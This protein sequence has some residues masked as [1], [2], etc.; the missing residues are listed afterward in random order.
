MPECAIVLKNRP[1]GGTAGHNERQQMKVLA[2]PSSGS[3]A[4]TTWSHNRG[5]QYT[6]NRRTP[7]IGTRTPRQ[8][9][10]KGNFA[11]ASR[12]WQTLSSADQNAWTSFAN[13]H[14][15][16]DRLGQSIKLT[17]HQF[18]VRV[19]AALLNVDQPTTTTVP[20]SVA[21][22]AEVVTAFQVFDTG[23]AY[24]LR[25]TSSAL[26]N[27]YA[28]LAKYTSLGANFQKTFHQVEAA[29]AD[30]PFLDLTDALA[31]WAGTPS[32]GTKAWLR[33][34]PVNQFG[35]TGQDLIVQTPVQ[36]SPVIPAPVLTSPAAAHFVATFA[37]PTTNL[38]IAFVEMNSAGVPFGIWTVNATTSSPMSIAATTGHY[39]K[40]VLVNTLTGQGSVFSNSILVT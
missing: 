23:P 25:Q 35:V 29:A 34:T 1:A 26:D 13:A 10:V 7:V 19:N 6:R 9:V 24:V 15:I 8:G 38:S 11:E 22:T 4:G 16:V 28:S 40:A 18:F 32:D 27:F 2:P 37:T 20:A 12:L 5:G 36:S 33:L 39:V 31:A 17:G 30:V 14:P 3:I 21:V